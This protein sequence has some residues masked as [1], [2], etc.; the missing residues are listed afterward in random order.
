MTEFILTDAFSL[1]GTSDISDH[2]KGLTTDMSADA[3]EITAFGDEWRKRLAGLK[4]ASGSLEGYQD[5][6]SGQIDSVLWPMVGT[7][8]DLEHRPTSASRSNNNPAYVIPIIV[9]GYSP[10]GQSVGEV[11]MWTLSWE[12][13]DE[14]QRRTS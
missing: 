9:T 1:I 7:K 3:E 6:A 4:D 5:F 12:L 11:A 8:Q 14:V 10:F 13:A 2:V